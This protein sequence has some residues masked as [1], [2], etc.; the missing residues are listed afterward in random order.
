MI[1]QFLNW[2]YGIAL[3]ITIA[4]ILVFY[5]ATK[6]YWKSKTDVEIH[7][8][9]I[10]NPM[11][12]SLTILGML[13]PLL[14]ALTAYL[15]SVNPNGN[16]SLLLASIT[17]LLI[18]LLSAIWLTFSL[19]KLGSKDNVI[20]LTFPSDIAFIQLS[21]IVYG[22]LIL[23]IFSIVVFFLFRFEY[24]PINPVITAIG[25]PSNSIYLEKP[26][27]QISQKK[28]DLIQLWGMPS[29]EDKSTNTFTYNTNNSEIKILLNSTDDINEITIRR[30]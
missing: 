6:H 13:I 3:S 19:L 16:F 24:K 28:L 11:S 30:K 27:I 26:M 15:L 18:T 2:E 7:A 23:G 8:D 14:A 9:F 25:I 17:I 4:F 12:I 22:L 21:G 10:R 29:G 5:F 20:K 1:R